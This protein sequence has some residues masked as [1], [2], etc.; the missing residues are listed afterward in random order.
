MRLGIVDKRD[1]SLEVPQK[2]LDSLNARFTWVPELEREDLVG[3]VAECAARV[4]VK[5]IAIPAYWILKEGFEWSSQHE[6]ALKGEKTMVYL[7][8]GGFVVSLFSPV[9]FSHTNLCFR[10]GMPFRLIQQRVFQKHPSN[11]LN[12]SPEYCRSTTDSA[13]GLPSPKIRSQAR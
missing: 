12:L 10:L 4:G 5:S 8:G 1:L 3:L 6:K 7:H 2:E 13:L 9:P 11:I